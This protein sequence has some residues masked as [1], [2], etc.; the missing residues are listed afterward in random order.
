MT[1]L[2]SSIWVSLYPTIAIARSL[3]APEYILGGTDL[4][5]RP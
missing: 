5:P 1:D 4:V 2:S 3:M